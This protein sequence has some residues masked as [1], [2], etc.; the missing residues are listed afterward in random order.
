MK[1]RSFM[2]QLKKYFP[3][4]LMA[5]PACVYFFINNY[6][7]MGGLILAFEKYT[8]RGGIFGSE[9]VGLNNFKFLFSNADAWIMT[10]NTILYNVAFII[11]GTV[12]SILVAYLLHEL[13]SNMSRKVYQTIILF[14]GLLSIIIVSYLAN[15]LLAGDTGYINMHILQPL[16]LEKIS[17]YSEQKWWPFIL[18]FI[19]LWQITGTNCILYL[20]NMSAID[21]GLYEAASL[22]GANRLNIFN[23]ITLPCL[24]P[25]II[26]LTILS[27]GKIF[28]SDFGLFYQ[29]PMNSGALIDVTQTIDTYVY[30]GLMNTANMGMSAAACFYQSVVGFVLVMITNSIVKKMSSENAMF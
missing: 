12:T 16:G 13:K 20:A 26:T 14:P 10:R 7:P 5:L 2:K 6:I 9:K 19:H 23:K 3:F 21:P 29:V 4:Y 27:V 1:K 24:I 28:N 30:R 22:D 18:T 15:A 8:V 17:F 25:T 11:L